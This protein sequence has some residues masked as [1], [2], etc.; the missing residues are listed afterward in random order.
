[1][2]GLSIPKDYERGIEIIK[3]LSNSDVDKIGEVLKNAPTEDSP[4]TISAVTPILEK[5]YE[6]NDIYVL[7]Q[8]LYSLYFVFS[9]RD[10]S[11]DHF[12]D[13]LCE[14]IKESSNAE[15]QTSDPAEL[16]RLKTKFKSL[17]TIRPLLTAAK[18][19]A[20]QI[21][22]ANVFWDAKIISD[23]RPIWNG[24]VKE[25]PEGVV[26]T[27]TLKL[28]YRNCGGQSELYVYLDKNDIQ[29][30]LTVLKRAQDKVLTLESLTNTNWMKILDN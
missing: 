3:S 14:A 11:I 29:T 23:I 27:H 7:V 25:P 17:L 15:V 19:H 22:F 2:P 28:E 8:T 9:H 20:L 26:V 10:D 12:V 5:E 6:E 16:A 18:A 1:M 30:L 24:D 21:E 4:G 13:D